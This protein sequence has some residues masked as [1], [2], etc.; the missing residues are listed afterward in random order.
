M[1][2]TP[3]GGGSADLLGLDAIP[4][5]PAPA[6]GGAG[7]ASAFLVDVFGDAAPP[8]TN[9]VTDNGLTPGAEDNLKKWV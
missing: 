2:V 3:P 9:G 7:G 6:A 8:V 5:A 1:P 4:S